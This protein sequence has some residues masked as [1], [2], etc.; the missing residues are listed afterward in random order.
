M[1]MFDGTASCPASRTAAA[2]RIHSSG[3]AHVLIGKPVATFPGHALITDHHQPVGAGL[4][5]PGLARPPQHLAYVGTSLVAGEGGVGLGRRVETLD[6][7]GRP[8]GGPDPVL[9][10]DVNRIGARFA[11]R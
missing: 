6:G 10:V 5:A 4:A 2:T 11:L 7:V 8:V 3:F 9:V 1:P